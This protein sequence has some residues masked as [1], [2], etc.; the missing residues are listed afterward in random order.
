MLVST[1]Q[2]RSIDI[3]PARGQLNREDNGVFRCLHSRLII[4][5]LSRET[6]VRS[7][8]QSAHF[9]NSGCISYL[10]LLWNYFTEYIP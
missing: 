9:P 1:F 4:I 8:R 10:L 5:N 3:N 7:L 6:C 2:R